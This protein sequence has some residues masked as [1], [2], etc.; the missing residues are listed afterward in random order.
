MWGVETVRTECLGGR[1]L[2]LVSSLRLDGTW[3]RLRHDADRPK[4]GPFLQQREAAR[5]R[6]WRRE[7]LEDDRARVGRIAEPARQ[8]S[9]HHGQRLAP[10]SGGALLAGCSAALASTLVLAKQDEGRGVWGWRRQLATRQVEH[11]GILRRVNLD[12]SEPSLLLGQALER[13]L[14]AVVQPAGRRQHHETPRLAY[15]LRLELGDCLRRV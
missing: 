1:L 12:D 9:G 6:L 15:A 13:L 5:Q 11:E 10:T 3:C 7:R 14:L 2:L 4:H 8:V